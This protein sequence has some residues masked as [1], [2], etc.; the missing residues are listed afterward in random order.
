MF[1]FAPDSE[2]HQVDA[3]SYYQP[4][5][6]APSPYEGYSD[7]AD[8]QANTAQSSSSSELITA[9][10]DP[11]ILLASSV[12]SVAPWV[13]GRCALQGRFSRHLLRDVPGLVILR[14]EDIGL[15]RQTRPAPVLAWCPGND[16]SC[17]NHPDLVTIWDAL[18]H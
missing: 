5:D 15:I 8:S 18:T 13:S 1:S 9:S 3:I 4:S 6:V 7:W 14:L 2:S 10:D 12:R 11:S 16:G 17:V